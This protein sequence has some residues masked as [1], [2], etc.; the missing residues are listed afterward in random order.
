MSGGAMMMMATLRA[1]AGLGLA[2]F[3]IPG[4]QAQSAR[5]ELEKNGLLGTFSGDCSK[6]VSESNGYIV[7]R[8]LDAQRVQRDTM[9]GPTTR[10]YVSVAETAK[11]SAINELTITGTADGKPI[12]YTLRLD[13]PRHR[14]MQWSENGVTSIVDGVWTA[15]KFTMP[16]ISKCG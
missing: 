1:G 16:W 14:V 9:T 4:A 6:P 8:A 13:G 10:G 2:L 3:A 7:Y 11:V 5:A 15:N 12:V